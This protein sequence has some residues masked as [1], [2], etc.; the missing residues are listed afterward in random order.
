MRCEIHLTV[1]SERSEGWE[2]K[3]CFTSAK[4]AQRSIDYVCH[5]WKEDGGAVLPKDI[6]RLREKGKDLGQI[7]SFFFF[8][9]SPSSLLN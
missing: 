5:F 3:N 2:I 1:L 6:L 9:S 8:F 4:Q 7:S